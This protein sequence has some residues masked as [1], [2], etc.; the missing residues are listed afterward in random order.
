MVSSV[1]FF[2][3]SKPLAVVKDQIRLPSVPVTGLSCLD[4]E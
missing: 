2:N 4:Q 3:I 1:V